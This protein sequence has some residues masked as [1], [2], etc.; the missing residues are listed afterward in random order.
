M[1]YFRTYPDVKLIKG[2]VRSTLYCLGN[3]KTI[4]LSKLESKI[5]NEFEDKDI[6]NVSSIYGDIIV[7]K[8]IECLLKNGLGAIY[9]GKVFAESYIP[10][11]PYVIR[12]YLEPIF[13]LEALTLQ[14]SDND[15]YG[16]M[17]KKPMFIY[18][19]CN[20]CIPTV[21]RKI[22]IKYLVSM[23]IN[24]LNEL[25]KI[26]IKNF[27]FAGGNPLK[28]WEDTKKIIKELKTNH[29]SVVELIIPLLD[30]SDN[31]LAEIKKYVDVLTISI[32]AHKIEKN[33]YLNYIKKI[34]DRVNNKHVDVKINL[35]CDNEFDFDYQQSIKLLSKLPLKHISSTDIL[36]STNDKLTALP[37]DKNRIEDIGTDQ[38]LFRKIKS[39]CLYGKIAINCNGEILPCLSHNYIMGNI[40]EGIFNILENNIHE[41]YWY[42]SKK[43]VSRC[44]NCE[45]RFACVDCS[46]FEEKI[47]TNYNMLSVICDYCPEKGI[48]KNEDQE[49]ED[50]V[51]RF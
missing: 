10:H 31:L 5:M 6:A 42:Y 48:W 23:I 3:S 33:D 13:E 37:T 44:C 21:H 35:I 47:T 46:A 32:L 40:K 39:S 43:D 24:S 28:H 11:M 1:K 16:Y 17:G 26:K 34:V 18:Q 50:F 12:G 4:Q 41:K 38:F 49:R 51:W 30:I 27:V 45:N 36:Y 2:N 29:N 9:E 7:N 15:Y 22:D 14:I 25:H 19:A 8:A 20:S